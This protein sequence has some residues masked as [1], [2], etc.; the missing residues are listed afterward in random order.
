MRTVLPVPEASMDA[1]ELDC[2]DALGDD[3]HT[4]VAGISPARGPSDASAAEEVAKAIMDTARVHRVT[5]QSCCR[6]RASRGRG[7][8]FGGVMAITTGTYSRRA[9]SRR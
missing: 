7:A 9:E 6:A 3:W 2:T 8:N 1:N 4:F 5:A